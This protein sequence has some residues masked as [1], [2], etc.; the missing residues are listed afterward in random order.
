MKQAVEFLKG[1]AALL[2]FSG[3]LFLS[4]EAID[5]ALSSNRFPPG[6][7]QAAEASDTATPAAPVA[8]DV[9]S[10]CENQ[11]RYREEL[12]AIYD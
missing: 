10:P 3:V 7:A 8:D 4:M 2:A 6:V 9:P 1:V 11:A 5:G 12:S